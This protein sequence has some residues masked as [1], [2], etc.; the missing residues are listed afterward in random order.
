M[1]PLPA[2]LL[3][4]V[5][6]KLNVLIPSKV[7][8]RWTWLEQ[9]QVTAVPVDIRPTSKDCEQLASTLSDCASMY[10]SFSPFI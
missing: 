2:V 6:T 10:S 1:L 9:G 3:F 4:S 5:S 7:P 8:Y